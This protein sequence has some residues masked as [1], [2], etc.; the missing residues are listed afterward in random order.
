M[1][2]AAP[3]GGAT[4]AVGGLLAST[5][6]R[7]VPLLQRCVARAEVGCDSIRAWSS[8]WNSTGGGV[9]T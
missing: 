2:A 8:R 4:S 6:R 7:V 9:N 1:A 3:I 5:E